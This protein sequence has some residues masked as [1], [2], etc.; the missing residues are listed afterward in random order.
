MTVSQMAGPQR[1]GGLG[2]LLTTPGLQNVPLLLGRQ[3]GELGP[4]CPQAQGGHRRLPHE[5]RA[6]AGQ[7]PTAV[8][9]RA[10]EKGRGLV[11]GVPGCLLARLAG[12]WRPLGAGGSCQ[13]SLPFVLRDPQVDQAPRDPGCFLFSLITDIKGGQAWGAGEQRRHAHQSLGLGPPC[14]GEQSRDKSWPWE[15][16]WVVLWVCSQ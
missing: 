10:S 12:P 2:S 7:G 3:A 11:Q 6:R 16:P 9:C 5:A 14:G 4:S 1:P 8:P 13:H 15:H